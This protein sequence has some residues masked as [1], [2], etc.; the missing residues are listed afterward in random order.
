M[1]RGRRR[2]VP[3]VFSCLISCQDSFIYLGKDKTARN[4][5]TEGVL[6]DEVFRSAFV[7]LNR[8]SGR[9]FGQTPASVCLQV[10]FDILT[11]ISFLAES[12]VFSLSYITS[13]SLSLPH[14]LASSARLLAFP[15]RPILALKIGITIKLVAQPPRVDGLIRRRLE[16]ERFVELVDDQGLHPLARTSNQLGPS[17]WSRG[18]PRRRRRGFGHPADRQGGFCLAV[19]REEGRVD[20]QVVYGGF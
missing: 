3:V 7:G 15:P 6:P 11:K 16:A 8:R 13:S 4:R 2:G 17:R 14:Q 12:R 18:S 9:W 1:P 10:N 20:Y 19:F 5:A